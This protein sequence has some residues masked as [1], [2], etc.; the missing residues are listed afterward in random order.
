MLVLKFDAESFFIDYCNG[1]KDVADECMLRFYNEATR[2][3]K[4]KGEVDLLKAEIEENYQTI[5]AKCWFY[6]NSIMESFGTG[7]KM[8]KDNPFLQEYWNSKFW[9]PNRN[10]TAI[11]G[12]KKGKYTNIFGEEVESTGS[13]AHLQDI[14]EFMKE[15]YN[16][17]IN[18]EPK[19]YIQNAEIKL[20]QGIN[21]GYVDRAI[22]AF[23]EEFLKD[24]TKYFYNEEQ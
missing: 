19:R 5:V 24:T 2:Q 9:N 7:T 4:F 18:K 1:L 11:A 15:K 21:G 6:A 14:S 23:T 20:E 22:D 8:D 17:N 10:S 12:R 13:L 3:S 16:L